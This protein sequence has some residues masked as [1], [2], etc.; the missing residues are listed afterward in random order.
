MN[1]LDKNFLAD[2]PDQCGPPCLS[3]Y[4]TTHRHHPDNQQDP[5]RFGNLVKSLEESLLTQ[6]PKDEAHALLEPFLALA[7][8]RDFWN[9]TLDGLA[10]LAAKGVFRVYTLPRPVSELVVVADSFHTKPLMHFLQS[11]DRYHV[12]GLNR[13]EVK[14]FEG[15]R[16]AL[17]E[18]PL[19]KNVPRTLTDALGEEL[20]DPRLTVASYGGAGGSQS[21]MHHGHGGKKAEVDI[22]ADRF[23]R[24]IDRAI[25]EFHSQPSGL[26]LILASLPEHHHMFHELS[27]N[28]YLIDES[29]DVHP[30]SLSSIDELRVRAWQ[31][32]EPR[33]LAQ[34]AS[35]VEEFGN[36]R[37]GE[38]GDDDVTHVARAVA[39]GRVAT[40]LIEAGREIP[41]RVNAE[42]GEIE[43]GDLAHPEV[44][45]ALDDLGVLALKMGGQVVIVP[46]EQM[47]TETGLAAIYRY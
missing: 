38:L 47:P 5:I 44:D 28:P 9:H 23:F 8:D 21:A 13:Q 18:I 17:H 10:I 42:T 15:N 29:V 25:L 4:Q 37:S 7:E 46:T 26:P 16:D 19:H 43:S 30:D 3:L 14:L 12:L 20:T 22:D 33:Y 2:F 1:I 36:A 41:G 34:L 27:D 32:M 6:L 24:L 40:L 35:L 11:V 45:D 31:R 39:N